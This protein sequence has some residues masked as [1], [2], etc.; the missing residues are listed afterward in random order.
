MGILDSIKDLADKAVETVKDAAEDAQAAYDEAGGVSGLMD[1]AKTELSELGGD[2]S[3]AASK[4]VDTV[5]TTATEAADSAKAAY[6]EVGGVSGMVDKAK[7]SVT[8]LADSA[9][10]AAGNVIDK[11]KGDDEAPKA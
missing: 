8:E 5:K 11:V 9:K 1:K 10:D 2:I 7:T 6:E 4:A 3:E